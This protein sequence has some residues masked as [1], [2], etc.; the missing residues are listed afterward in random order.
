M[1][2]IHN[3]EDL[4][5][6]KK[7]NDINKQ[8]KEQRLK[9]KLGRQ[10]FH[11]NVK[12]LF[13]PVTKKQTKIDESIK[14]QT[15]QLTENQKQSITNTQKITGAINRSAHQAN[16]NFIQAINQGIENYGEISKENYKIL[17]DLVNQNKISVLIGETLANLLNNTNPQFKLNY[18]YKDDLFNFLINNAP[19]IIKGTKMIFENGREYNLLDQSLEHFL[20][21]TKIKREQIED[22]QL[23]KDFL[24]DIKYKPENN[25]DRV[26]ERY[27]LINHLLNFPIFKPESKS[28]SKL[29]SKSDSETEEEQ[30]TSAA[31]LEKQIIIISSNPNELV[32]KL[33]VLKSQI[34]AGNDSKLIKSEIEAIVDQLLN[35]QIINKKEHSNILNFN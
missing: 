22:P 30:S 12:E 17:I 4:E 9:K 1:Y 23:I 27:R 25:K 5:K 3:R 34:Q 33:R 2:S 26:S 20:N 8:L 28:E 29:E 13:E 6:L 10:D 31:G 21:N 15:N 11:F 18:N 32:D 16:K 7:L 24:D 14:Q 35:L 19:V